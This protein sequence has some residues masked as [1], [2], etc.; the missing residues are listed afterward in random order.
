MKDSTERENTAMDAI[1]AEIYRRL[2]IEDQKRGMLSSVFGQ[3][4]EDN[5][6]RKYPVRARVDRRTGQEGV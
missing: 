2:L 4:I 3:I 1:L 6:E 5:D